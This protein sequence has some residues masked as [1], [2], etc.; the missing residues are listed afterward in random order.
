M[1]WTPARGSSSRDRSAQRPGP[2]RTPPARTSGLHRQVGHHPLR[3]DDVDGLALVL[4][5][6]VQ[7]DAR[8]PEGPRRQN[9]V[10][11]VHR[12]LA[13]CKEWRQRSGTGPRRR[14]A[15][16]TWARL[17]SEKGKGCRNVSLPEPGPLVSRRPRHARVTRQ[18]NLYAAR[19]GTDG[20]RSRPPEGV[21]GGRERRGSRCCGGLVPHL[22]RGS[23]WRDVEAGCHTSPESLSCPGTG[24]PSLGPAQPGKDRASLSFPSL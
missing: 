24:W 11:P 2:R 19:S 6:V 14:G 9:Q 1:T 5:L 21:R 22:C 7:G 18:R 8:D 17:T 20:T 16:H 13:A 4:A 10:P 15:G 23:D 3:A 12:E